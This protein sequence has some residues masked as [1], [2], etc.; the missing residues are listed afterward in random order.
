MRRSRPSTSSRV[1]SALRHAIFDESRQGRAAEIA[2]WS[3]AASALA[4]AGGTTALTWSRIPVHAAW[5]GLVAGALTLLLLRL[6]LTHR[7]TVWIAS[8]IGTL[9]LSALGGS[10]AWLFAHVL[11]VAWAPS[12]AAVVGALLA[13]LPPA[14]GYAQIARRRAECVRDSL[15]DPISVPRSR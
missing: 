8:A 13:A 11:E 10:L 6:A 4:V 12:V 9:T 14:W 5:V 3:N 1:L 7:T 2:G 15:I